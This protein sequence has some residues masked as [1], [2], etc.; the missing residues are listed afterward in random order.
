MG[1]QRKLCKNPNRALTK[2]ILKIT[3]TNFII[4]EKPLGV[5]FSIAEMRERLVRV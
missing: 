4:D 5:F 3:L 2:S 1:I